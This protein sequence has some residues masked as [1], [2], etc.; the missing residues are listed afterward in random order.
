ML[1][2]ATIIDINEALPRVLPLLLHHGQPHTAASVANARP[3]IEWPGLFVTEYTM[4]TRN[5]LFDPVRDANPIFHY[6]EAM[7]IIAGRDD[8][9]FLAHVLPRYKDYSDNGTTLHGAYGHRL[10]N[11]PDFRGREI[12]QIEESIR[13]LREAPASRQVVMAIWD[14]IKD[15]GHKGKDLPCNDTVMLKIRNGK[16]NITVANRSNDA[17]LGCYGANA[18]Q[19]SML[20]MYMAARIGVGVGTYCQVSDSLHVYEDNPYWQW[21][22]ESY[23]RNPNETVITA[24]AG[25]DRQLP[26]RNLFDDLPDLVDAELKKFFIGTEVSVRGGEPIYQFAR[27]TAIRNAVCMWNALLHYRK[28][29]HEDA[30]AC[31]WAVDSPDWAAACRE[32]LER[33]IAAKAAKE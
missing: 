8:L 3:T 4:P 30:L 29:Q 31:A 17:V 22:K 2:T 19:F 9:G 13:I 23:A 7:W 15:L 24:S 21:F 6:L 18:V 20:Q 14:P 11:W 33:R 28:G 1:G 27:S 10:R 16:L 32:W 5:V 26:I 12:D 25:R